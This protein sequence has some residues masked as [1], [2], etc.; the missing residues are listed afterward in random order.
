MGSVLTIHGVA[1]RVRRLRLTDRFIVAERAFDHWLAAVPR[2]VPLSEA[3]AGEG[4]ALT[5]DDATRGSARA[6]RMARARGHSVTLFVNPGQ[7]EAGAPYAL[8][9][10][11]ALLDD[12]SGTVLEFEGACHDAITAGDR[13]ALRTH[14]KNRLFALKDEAARQALITALAR[15]WGVP[16]V[17]VP[18]HLR[19]L[20]PA[21]LVSLRDAGIDIQNHGWSHAH[22]SHLAPEESAHDVREGRAWLQRVLQIDAPY[23]AVPF[24][25][26]LP[27]ELA[28]RECT[29]WFTLVGD[30]PPGTR[31]RQVFNRTTPALAARGFTPR[32]RKRVAP[33]VGALAGFASRLRRLLR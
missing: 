21:D 18:D 33:A 8:A 31:A 25:D 14:V 29:T 23:F 7:V 22:H 30:H 32:E 27:S 24:G 10:L 4:T 19:T 2:F 1:E 26:A 16:N 6:A 28:L 12:V 9:L 20:E 15:E 5:I 13:V 11:S 17:T 3:L